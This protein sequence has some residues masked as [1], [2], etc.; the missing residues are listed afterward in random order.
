MKDTT[1][2]SPAPIRVFRPK[3]QIHFDDN[4]R[5]PAI[6]RGVHLGTVAEHEASSGPGKAQQVE[7][8]FDPE[9]DIIFIDNYVFEYCERP[10]ATIIFDVENGLPNNLAAL[11]NVAIDASS[12]SMD[13]NDV[14]YKKL[15]FIL[16]NFPMVKRITIIATVVLDIPSPEYMSKPLYHMD[17][18]NVCVQD[19][20]RHG[21]LFGEELQL[22]RYCKET[23]RP[24]DFAIQAWNDLPNH[25]PT[26]KRRREDKTAP[27]MFVT[28]MVYFK[29]EW[30]NLDGEGGPGGPCRLGKQRL[31]IAGAMIRK[32]LNNQAIGE[33]HNK[34]LMQSKSQLA[35]KKQTSLFTLRKKKSTLF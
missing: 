6:F 16:R 28:A 14:W 33:K 10:D 19:R 15:R 9:W 1:Y 3:W 35:L 31:D 7:K 17:I 13:K 30:I 34:R 22:Y 29:K 23:S 8:P 4:T 25:W 11:Q 21:I 2:A 24:S 27:C 5:Y 18:Q 32:K 20:M 26:W 12:L